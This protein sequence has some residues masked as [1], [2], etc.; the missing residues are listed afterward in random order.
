MLQGQGRLATAERSA[1]G[2][3]DSIDW[4]V[5]EYQPQISFMVREGWER[6]K[7]EAYTLLACC[8]TAAL[9]RAPTPST[10]TRTLAPHL[11]L[12]LEPEPE[13]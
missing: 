3:P 4:M 8:G 9:G 5:Q 10:G 6:W 1:P 11:P 12:A 13:P 2:R 7:A